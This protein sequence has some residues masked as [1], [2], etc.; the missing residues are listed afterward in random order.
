MNAMGTTSLGSWLFSPEDTVPEGE[1]VVHHEL[2]GDLEVVGVQGELLVELGGPGSEGGQVVP[3][4]AREVVV[5]DVVPDVQVHDV[6]LPQVVVRLHLR[7]VLEVLRQD[8]EGRRVRADRQEPAQQDIAQSPGTHQLVQQHVVYQDCYVVDQ[9]VFVDWPVV[10]EH[11][12]QRIHQSDEE[13]EQS[14]PD[15]CVDV[16]GLYNLN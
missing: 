2:V 7:H 4:D 11:R 8:V 9:L 10:E 1:V 12:P 14:L 3:G 6:E 15:F 16:L 13:Q 5:L